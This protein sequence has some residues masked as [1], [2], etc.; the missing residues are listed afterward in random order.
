MAFGSNVLQNPFAQA[1][2]NGPQFNDPGRRS[3]TGIQQ[4][5]NQQQQENDPSVT[6]LEDNKGFNPDLGNN[7]K[8][9]S[10]DPMLEFDKLW[11]DT[12]VDPKNP[13]KEFKGYLPEIDQTKFQEQ[14][15]KLD[16]SK[17]ISPETMQKLLTGGPEAAEAWPE[18]INAIGRQSFAMAFNASTKMTNAGLQNAEKRFTE[19][20]IPNSIQNRLV[21]DTFS[22]NPLAQDPE[23]AGFL[24]QIKKQYTAKFPKAS[25]KAISDAANKYLESIAAK[26]TKKPNQDS[27][28]DNN[29]KL[30]RG[31]DGADWE[32]WIK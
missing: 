11:E 32:E 10:N 18:M 5:P 14:L 15:G 29:T 21:N 23:V 28:L 12:P 2:N 16:F 27:E 24:N 1:T 17:S 9:Q 3:P 26:A 20:L 8:K 19:D 30:S 4:Q 6:N 13:P 25:P 22:D 31:L 7:N